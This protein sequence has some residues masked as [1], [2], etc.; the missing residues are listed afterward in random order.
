MFLLKR[1]VK[2]LQMTRDLGLVFK[3]NSTRIYCSAD[4]SFATNI[5]ARSQTGAIVQMGSNNAPLH[6]GSKKQKLVAASSTEAEMIA[7]TH[8]AQEVYWV[9]EIMEEIGITMQPAIIH[10][11]NQSCMTLSYVGP[12]K[13]AKSRAINIKYFWVKQFLDQGRMILEYTPS[14]EMLADGLTK[15]LQPAQFIPW[16]TEILNLKAWYE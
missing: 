12:G 4:A 10:Q 8:A 16:R 9:M 13:T 15:P 2:Y 14:S 6:V 11:D 7:L 5:D 1:I 3:P